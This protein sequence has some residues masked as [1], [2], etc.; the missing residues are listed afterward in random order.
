MAQSPLST[1]Y[2][3]HLYCTDSHCNSTLCHRQSMCILTICTDHRYHIRAMSCHLDISKVDFSS[4]TIIIYELHTDMH[5]PLS[6]SPSPIGEP[7]ISWWHWI[8]DASCMRQ[9]LTT[10]NNNVLF[11]RTI[12]LDDV[13]EN[14]ESSRIFVTAFVQQFYMYLYASIVCF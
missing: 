3:H 6:Q 8:D 12:A 5:H 7:L 9:R 11:I 13:V 4:I 1:N 2:H 14:V 10:T